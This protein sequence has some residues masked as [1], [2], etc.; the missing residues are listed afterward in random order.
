V[1][2]HTGGVTAAVGV[3]RARS[4]GQFDPTLVKLFEVE[5]DM[6]FTQLHQVT[7]WDAVMSKAPTASRELADGELD[8]VLLAV[9]DFVDLKSPFTLGHSRGVAELTAGAAGE[10]GAEV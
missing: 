10:L 8:R 6:I 4:G 9:A 7:T 1:F 3:A 5:A 2:Y